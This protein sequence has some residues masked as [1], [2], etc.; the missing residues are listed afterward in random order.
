MTHYRAAILGCGGR[1]R[2]HAAGYAESPQAAIVG[3][4]DPA[5]ENART[6]AK[7]HPGAKVYADY[8]ELLQELHPEVVSICTWPHLHREMVEAALEA[9]AKAIHCE[10]PMATTWGEARQMAAACERAGTQLTFN[11]QRRFLA[12]FRVARDLVQEGAIGELRRLEAACGDM[13]DWGTH[14][15]DMCFFYNGETP[16]TW[17][18][19]QIDAREPH[20]IFGVALENQGFSQFKF[21][22]GV[23]AL[24]FT[25]D[26]HEIG[27]ANRLIGTEGV[28]EV[29]NDAPHVRVRGR[30]EGHWRT[31][32]TPEGLHGN[33]AIDKGIADM[34][35]AMEQKREPEM[36]ARKALRTTE[37]IFA[38]YESSR[39]R[40]RVDLPLTID[41]SPLKSMLEAGEV[42]PAS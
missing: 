36:S 6:L 30:G 38:T 8:R 29:H 24:I 15:I 18:L 3:C 14:W 2:A 42:G 40:G 31:I 37:V 20:T 22:N 7:A 23:R 28:I 13:Y 17:V 32:D 21:E 16:A 25:G 11:H 35:E 19:G 9:K 39:R 27:C 34:I 1:G 5:V 41:D 4:A 10:K 26:D 33:Q 12:P